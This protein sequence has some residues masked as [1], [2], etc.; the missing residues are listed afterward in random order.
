MRFL[1]R[2]FVLGAL[3]L[4]SAIPATANPPTVDPVAARKRRRAELQRF[5]GKDYALVLGQPLTDVL[6]PRQ[7]GHFLYLTGVQDPDASLLLVGRDATP[8]S[9]PRRGEKPQEAREVLFL[10]NASPRFVQ[11]YG[12]RYLPGK[13]SAKDLAVECA[14]AAPR[15]GRGLA[16]RLAQWLPTDAR[17]RLP[18]YKRP[19]HITV[20]AIRKALVKELAAARPDIV[21]TDLTLQLRRQRSIKDPGEIRALERAVRITMTAFRETL[22]HLR[23]GAT[24]G[25]VDGAL[26]FAV[27]RRRAQP[28]Y[29]FVV[30]AGINAAIPHYF[31]NESTLRAGDLIVIDA[32]AEVDRYAADITRTYPVSGRFTPRQR[33]V[34][35][36]VLR[37]QEAAIAAV[38]PGATLRTVD[39]AARD[40]LKEAKLARYFIHGTSH[41]VGLDVHDPGIGPLQPGMLITVEPGVY[42]RDERLGVRIE[43][44]VL[45]TKDGCRV[46]SADLPKKAAEIEAALRAARKQAPERK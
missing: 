46:L 32:G 42:I 3:V 35:D 26:L 9:L 41:H 6:L 1:L 28:A 20:R 24:E 14:R 30:A 34:Y 33:T 31:R 2:G 7:E 38:R 17:L 45:V 29:R 39:K 40:I 16:R 43:D 15:G 21:L 36:A 19:D 22:K 23:P 18:A 13:Q 10:R 11:F 44:V 12:L 4:A 5:L 37:A 8:L 25:E 27:R